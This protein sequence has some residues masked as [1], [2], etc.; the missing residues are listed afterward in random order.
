MP[1]STYKIKLKIFK[2][3]IKKREFSDY[4]QLEC[5]NFVRYS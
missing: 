3:Q 4:I 2:I 5:A 1:K